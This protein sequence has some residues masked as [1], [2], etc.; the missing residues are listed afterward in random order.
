MSARNRRGGEM[1]APPAKNPTEPKKTGMQEKVN[2]LNTNL[3]KV[4]FLTD[5]LE[6]IVVDIKSYMKQILIHINHLHIY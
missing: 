1:Y 5:A 2:Q 4:T 3:D 6:S